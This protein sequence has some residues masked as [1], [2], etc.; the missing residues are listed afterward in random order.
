[1]FAPHAIGPSARAIVGHRFRKTKDDDERQERRASRE[2]ELLLRQ[3]RQDASFQTDY[4]ADEGVDDDEERE[5][6]KVLAKTQVYGGG[7]AIAV[8]LMATARCHSWWRPR[9]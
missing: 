5:L 3:R 1:M 2:V 7:I 6:R 4:R 9:S 8:H